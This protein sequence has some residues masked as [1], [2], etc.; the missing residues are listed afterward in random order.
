[1]TFVSIS[2]SNISQPL[3]LLLLL[4]LLVIS[5]RVIRGNI[6][7]LEILFGHRNSSAQA[8]YIPTWNGRNICQLRMG[9]I[10]EHSFRALASG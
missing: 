4:L 10:Q 8:D 7:S 3:L 1:M 6:A 2:A 5:I 9:K